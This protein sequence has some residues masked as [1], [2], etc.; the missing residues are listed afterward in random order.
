MRRFL[1]SL[2]AVFM[3]TLSVHSA[4]EVV[5]S[6]GFENGIPSTW[7]DTVISYQSASYQF[8]WAAETNSTYLPTGAMEGDYRAAIR[9]TNSRS[10]ACVTRLITPVMDC[11]VYQPRL[12]FA[13]AQPVKGTKAVDSLMIYYRTSPTG[14]WT[15]LKT[16]SDRIDVWQYD[17][18]DLIGGTSTYQLAFEANITNG[19]GI[20]IDDIMVAA[21]P[22][23]TDVQSIGVVA[24]ATSAEITIGAD[25]SAESF[26]VV[27]SETVLPI[28]MILIRR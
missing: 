25:L 15:L 22:Q 8:H 17:T 6:E 18:L 2:L 10:R 5:L 9:N 28:G 23:C 4:A 13:H 3:V 20:V 12:I 1:L 14:D 24:M 11:A 26:Q 16:Y 7:T 21:S 27:V 19:S